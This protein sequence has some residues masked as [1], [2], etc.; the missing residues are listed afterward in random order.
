[1]IILVMCLILLFIGM[2]IKSLI[3]VGFPDYVSLQGFSFIDSVNHSQVLNPYGHIFIILLFSKLLYTL[4]RSYYTK[5]FL[6][7]EIT[8]GKIT[9]VKYSS[10][11]VNNK[12]L[13]DLSV[14]YLELSAT[15]KDQPGDFGFEFNKGDIIPVRYQR[16]KPE[17]AVIPADAIDIVKQHSALKQE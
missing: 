16:G 10:N 3:E 7:T 2:N 8:Y 17:I 12:P 9:S 13:I 5:R 15:F 11:R 1:M 14:D 4:G 6:A